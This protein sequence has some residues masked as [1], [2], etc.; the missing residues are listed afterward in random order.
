[1]TTSVTRSF[2]R[3][4]N[5]CTVAL[6]N[7]S[8]RAAVNDG[9][10][11]KALLLFREMKQSGLEPDNLTF[12]SIAK[13]CG[14][15]SNL[16]HSQII[17]T[18]VVKSPFWSDKFVQTATVDMYVKC[19][20]LE[21]AHN[22]FERMPEKDVAS[23]NTMI[24]GFAQLGLLDRVLLLFCE[25][26]FIGLKPDSI[27]IIGLTQSSSYAKN[28]NMVK[29]IHCFGIQI[30]IGE[31]VSVTNTWIAAYAKCDDLGLAERVFRGIP[32]EL[33]TVV[34]W[35]SMVAGY[36]YLEKFV[37]AISFY[38]SMCRNGVKPDISTILS[39][40]SSCVHPEALL[41]GKLIHAHGIR[42]GCDSDISVT[43]TLISVY[44]TSGDID[45]A[46]YLFNRMYERTCVSWTAMISGYAK[47]G[48]V[49]E[50]LALFYAMEAAGHKPDMVTVVA[51]LSACGQTGALELGRWINRYAIANGFKESVIVCNALIDMYAK[52][53]SIDDA[54]ELFHTMPERTT[55]SWTTMISGYALNGEFEEALNLFSNMMGLGLKPN[56]ITF[57]AVLQACT[58]AGFLEKGWECFDLMTKVYKLNPGLEHYAC[59][60]DLLGRRGKLKEALKFIQNMPVK[61]DAGV[62]GALLGACKIHRD[63]EIGEY[64]ADHLFGLEPQ[65]AVSYV[66]MANIYAAEGRWEGVARIRAMMKCNRVRKLPGCSVIQVNGKIHSFTVEDRGHHVCLQIYEVLDGLALQLKEVGFRPWLDTILDAS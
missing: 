19:G 15:L 33:R 44:S 28:L 7:S 26:R 12:P 3:F 60:T 18:H 48:D 25:M 59:M 16:R 51:L 53:G 17:H 40:L 45:S 32:T 2:N 66:A 30:G 11:D 37:D 56:Y 8:I 39:L 4:S 1:M 57:L 20:N 63:V 34:S 13:A 6:W 62:W 64:V 22:L 23:W 65:T 52:C 27:T 41:Q 29:A 38:Q 55:V 47:K 50:A 61:A 21:F 58:H 35:N 54:S 9:C 36:A 49:D 43:N 42:W 5:S 24:M 14:K 31:N 10:C 46:R